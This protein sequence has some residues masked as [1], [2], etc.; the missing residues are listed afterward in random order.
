MVAVV[1]RD[2]WE[3]TNEQPTP[4]R[5]GG[6]TR[7]LGVIVRAVKVPSSLIDQ[8]DSVVLVQ[9]VSVLVQT[10]NVLVQTVSVLVQTVSVLVQTV[11]VLVQTVNSLNQNVSPDSGMLAAI[12]DSEVFDSI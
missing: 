11:N 10:V 5:S 2:G 7:V 8:F 9:S 3:N 6:R 12:E 1:A 4:G